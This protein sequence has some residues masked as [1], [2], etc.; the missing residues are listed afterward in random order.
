MK[1]SSSF[2]NTFWHSINILFL[3]LFFECN[4]FSQID[5]VLKD[6]NDKAIANTENPVAALKGK[7]YKPKTLNVNMTEDKA[8]KLVK[9]RLE[10][11]IINWYSEPAYYNE[12]TKIGYKVVT[13]NIKVTEDYI[14]FVTRKP[15]DTVII[16][17]SEVLL[18]EIHL[19]APFENGVTCRLKMGNHVFRYCQND[20]ADALYFMRYTYSVKYYGQEIEKFKP[21]SEAYIAMLEKPVITEEQRKFMKQGMAMNEERQYNRAVFLYNKAMEINPIA[22]PAGYF[23]LALI[24]SLAENYPFAIFCMKKYLMMMPNAEDAREAQDKIYEWEAHINN[25][26]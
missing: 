5:Q 6:F 9:N 10:K 7:I 25:A 16:P 1:I 22:Y 2:Y 15:E 26:Y 19:S 14:L 21:I 4:A 24:A 13:N 3:L 20:M 17:F 23:N 11:Y 8:I 18:D 12:K